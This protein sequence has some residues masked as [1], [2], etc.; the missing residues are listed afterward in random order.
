MLRLL[1]SC[2]FG[3]TLSQHGLAIG[4]GS[5]ALSRE[6]GISGR[7]GSP[8]M[9]RKMTCGG[10]QMP[11]PRPLVLGTHVSERRQLPRPRPL[12]RPQRAPE[13]GLETRERVTRDR[14]P[15]HDGHRGCPARNT[16]P[17]CFEGL[18]DGQFSC[19]AIG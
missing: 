1:A 3:Q 6:G 16:A 18:R 8:R 19:K 14:L 9:L 5:P 10:S 4:I 17:G 2:V 13:Y 7:E 15:A 12:K 11:L